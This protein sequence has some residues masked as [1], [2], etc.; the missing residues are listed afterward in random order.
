MNVN[1]IA[2]ECSGIPLGSYV[3]NARIGRVAY[4]SML[5][6]L[7]QHGQSRPHYFNLVYNTTVL[8]V[9]KKAAFRPLD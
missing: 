7:K 4:V 1:Q 5:L 3:L 9:E 8:H 6:S 2:R